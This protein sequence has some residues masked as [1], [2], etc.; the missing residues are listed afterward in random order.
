MRP[1]FKIVLLSRKVKDGKQP[2]FLRATFQRESKY[3]PLNRYCKPEQFDKKK[4]RFRTGFPDYI[5][6][7]DVL[8]AIEKRAADYIRNCEREATPFDFHAFEQAVFA[9]AQK[10]AGKLVWQWCGEIADGLKNEG[11]YGNAEFYHS[12]ANAVKS[13]SARSTLPQVDSAWLDKFEA[14]MRKRGAN[15]GGISLR[16]KTLRSACNIA[17]KSG[18]MPA[19]WKPF[20]GRSFA[21]LKKS[22]K[23]RAIMLSDIRLIRDAPLIDPFERLSR[24]L[25]MFSFYCWGMN[26]ADIAELT[27]DNLAGLRVEYVRK[28]T[29]K[30]FS[31]NLS[32]EAAA[33]V[34][35]WKTGGKYLFPIYDEKRH[36]TAAQK[37]Q[38]RRHFRYRMNAALRAV[39]E[40]AGVEPEGFTFYVA[41]HTYATALKRAG[42]SPGLI[43]DVLGHSDIRTTQGY[44][45]EF[46]RGALDAANEKILEGL[47]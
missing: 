8:L 14:F 2:V 20:A 40:A 16:L 33:I 25:F 21:H 43:Q 29:G 3:F 24:D 4:C 9:Q 10:A 44:L 45:A 11:R 5:A 7:N 47:E 46:E 37:N 32:R 26:L 35:T 36:N 18:I 41:R 1:T 17:R 34:D 42:F 38:R 6:E 31:V 30:P 28:K 22:N 15:G 13:F 19:S 12:L 27:A 39:C 23:K